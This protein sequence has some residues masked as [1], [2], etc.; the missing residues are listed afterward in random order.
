MKLKLHCHDRHY[1]EWDV[2]DIDTHKY[3]NKKNVDIDPYKHKLFNMDTFLYDSETKY[4]ELIHSSNRSMP[5]IPGILVFNTVHNNICEFYPDD[6]R[7]PIFLVNYG[8]DDVTNTKKQNRF[9][10]I[11]FKHWEYKQPYGIIKTDIGVVSNIRNFYT[12]LLYRKSLHS[13]THHITRE[14][15]KKLQW[16]NNNSL[17]QFVKN[18]Y[19]VLERL[20]DFNIYTIDA[21]RSKEFDDGFS[22]K[23]IDDTDV[24]RLSIYITNVP[25]VLDMFNLWDSLSDRIQHIYLPDRKRPILSTTICDLLFSLKKGEYRVAFT[26]DI[27]VNKSGI[28]TNY[29]Y[30]NN[31]I[32]VSENYTYNSDKL[33]NCKDYK[34]VYNLIK[35]MNDIENQQYVSIVKDS[36]SA[37]SYMMILANHLCC[38]NLVK[39]K[40]GIFRNIKINNYINIPEHVPLRVKTFI[41]MW[42]S[43]NGQY[44]RYDKLY[45]D[46]IEPLY[47]YIRVTSPMRRVT[48]IINMFEIQMNDSLIK[49]SANAKEFYLRWTDESMLTY[50]NTT[51]RCVRRIKWNSNFVSTCI[52]TPDILNKNYHGYSF[53][54]VTRNDGLYQYMIYFPEIEY[55]SKY[56]TQYE[57]GEYACNQFKLNIFYDSKNQRNKVMISIVIN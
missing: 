33:E 6:K 45:V 39:N 53:D 40:N 48:D 17:L 49:I 2:Y 47:P 24:Y 52:K 51:H 15:M 16:M 27:D 8:V 44:V 26:I 20:C 29:S 43:S 31:I 54:G 34:E 5:V 36:Q 50:I 28:I 57:L 37:I 4:I 18:K 25:I 13:T 3:I 12:Y 55:L 21:S 11:Q 42:N 19:N 22:I 35:K 30:S 10:I 38:N 23:Y 1:H 32:C 41:K 46:K 14:N 9:V 56:T 7:L